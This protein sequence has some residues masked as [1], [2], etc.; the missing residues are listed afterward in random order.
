[1]ATPKDI[2]TET[3]PVSLAN[4]T[5]LDKSKGLSGAD[6]CRRFGLERS[7]VSAADRRYKGNPE[8]FKEWTSQNDPQ[9]LSW[10]PVGAGKQKKYY[11]VE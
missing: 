10:Y 7:G 9:G 3:K 11:P 8:A 4:D 5:P 1:M 6:L 2:P